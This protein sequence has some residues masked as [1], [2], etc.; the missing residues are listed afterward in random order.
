MNPSH[1]SPIKQRLEL[2]VAELRDVQDGIKRRPDGPEKKIFEE[3]ASDL[4]REIKSLERAYR[5][6]FRANP[7]G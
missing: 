1:D 3:M 7:Y 6:T 4:E 5:S 2:L